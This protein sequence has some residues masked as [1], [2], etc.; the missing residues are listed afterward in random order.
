MSQQVCKI[1]QFVRLFQASQFHGLLVEGSKHDGVNLPGLPGLDSLAQAAEH[2]KARFGTDLPQHMVGPR[3]GVLKKL[4]MNIDHSGNSYSALVQ[5]A[6]SD[7]HY[8]G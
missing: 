2:M 6:I 3:A 7:H 4:R 5:A 1:V 8:F